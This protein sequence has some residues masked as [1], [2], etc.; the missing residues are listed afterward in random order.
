MQGKVLIISNV[1]A[2]LASFRTELIEQLSKD[3]EV[4]VLAS[5]NGRKEILES[6]GAR[7][8]SVAME[9]HGINPVKELKLVSFYKHKIKEIQPQI[10]LTYTI[11]PNIYAGIAAGK[12]GIPVLANVTG[13]GP[14][15]E[16]EGFMQRIAIPLYRKGLKK[17]RKVFF[18][19][20]YNRDFMLEHNMVRN[21][22]Y[23]MIP[24]SGVNLNK[25]TLQSYP[26]SETIDF[27]FISRIVKEKGID[28]YLDA[29]KVVHE[30]HPE[31][32]F[33]V[34]GDCDNEYRSLIQQLDDEKI[35]IYHGRIDDIAGMHRQCACTIHPSYYPEGM[36]NVLLE[37]CANGRPIITTDRPGCREAVDD[38]VNGFIVKQ[39]DSKDLIE[40]IE[41]FLNLNW[42]QRQSMGIE[43][44]KKVEREFDRQIVINKY[45]DEIRKV[46]D[47]HG[48]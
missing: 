1:T 48:L 2:G 33:H 29:A 12:L 30:R 34:C 16:H 4:I 42:E 27:V 20:Q 22:Q 13:L 5:D 35:I 18:Q 44:R 25:Y 36:S 31:T 19:N 17:A 9:L 41:A 14:A 40:K 26:D 15:V 38:G 3:Y 39:R 46:I 6:A 7:V 10:I 47:C 21:D 24:G 37:A 45:I 8:L 28:Q 43:A 23:L 11:K 32:R